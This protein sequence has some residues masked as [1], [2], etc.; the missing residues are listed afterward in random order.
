MIVASEGKGSWCI[1]FLK[2][3]LKVTLDKDVILCS[4][5]N[6]DRAKLLIHS[7]FF[8]HEPVFNKILPYITWSGE[9][10]IA[11]GRN[12]PALF[13]IWQPGHPNSFD[14]PYIVVA[15]FELQKVHNIKFDLQDL[16]VYKG[17][18]PEFLAYCASRP[19]P[20]RDK[21]FSLFPKGH[22]L[23]K[24]QTTPGKR[25]DGHWHV[26]WEHYKPYRFVFA[27]E[28]LKKD[29]YVT[30][31]LLNALIAGS[32]P[33]YYGDSKWVKS[34]FNEKCI[35]FVDDFPSLEDCA[36]Y[37]KKVDNTPALY[38]KYTEEKRFVKYLGYFSED[39]ICEEYKRM[40][41]ILKPFIN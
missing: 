10:C 30:E 28:N 22:G 27:M 15:F 14:I 17:E 4:K 32:I 6:S 11:P 25:V 21:L 36:E 24:C 9:N 40:V 16:R 38:K 7:M 18:K 26:I 41:D 13:H 39:I 8:N 2:H 37:V 31:K 1:D 35:I 5:E 29:K 33:I 3:V 19:V 12:Y 34:V 23:G 20:I